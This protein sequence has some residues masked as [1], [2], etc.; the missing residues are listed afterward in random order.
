MGGFLYRGLLMILAKAA[1]SY[2]ETA[3]DDEIVVMSLASGDCFSLTGTAR[4][5]WLRIDGTTDRES[6]VAGLASDYGVSAEVIGAD[7]D[8]FVAQ[9]R[10][11]G[12]LAAG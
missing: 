7:V 10:G 1:G 12:L 5:I 4:D 9:L 6:L 3:I 8:D 2:T 11:A